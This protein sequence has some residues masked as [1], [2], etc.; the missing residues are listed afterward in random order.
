MF[1]F[2]Y[3]VRYFIWSSVELRSSYGYFEGVYQ[4]GNSHLYKFVYV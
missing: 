3:V 1:M 2:I 4:I